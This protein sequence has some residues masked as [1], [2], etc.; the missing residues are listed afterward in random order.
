MAMSALYARDN[1]S[2]T[3][4]GRWRPWKV[5]YGDDY[6]LIVEDSSSEVPG[7]HAEMHG[8]PQKWAAASYTFGQ[9]NRR[10]WHG[11][12]R[13][14]KINIEEFIQFF[15]KRGLLERLGAPTWEGRGWWRFPLQGYP[16]GVQASERELRDPQWVQAWHGTTIY[17]AP[18]IIRYG[19]GPS[20]K[21]NHRFFDERPGVYT[22]TN[23][24]DTAHK[25]EGYVYYSVLMPGSG[26]LW[27]T[28]FELLGDF[29][30]KFPWN[31]KKK[32]TGEIKKTDQSIFRYPHTRMVAMWAKGMTLDLADPSEW[33]FKSWE[34]T[35]EFPDQMYP[36]PEAD[37]N[38]YV[39]RGDPDSAVVDQLSGRGPVVQRP[40]GIPP[41]PNQGRGD[42]I[43]RLLSPSAHSAASSSGYFVPRTDVWECEAAQG[44][45]EYSTEVCDGINNAFQSGS[46][47]VWEYRSSNKK[48]NADYQID[49]IAGT[50]LNPNTG[51]VRKIRRKHPPIN[52]C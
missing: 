19:V 39:D 36:V 32:S 50:Q 4:A 42:T 20:F 12:P 27:G 28:K 30:E 6:E 23:I 1:P 10:V 14:S 24:N 41:D 15:T 37:L 44:W 5:A 29:R 47:F 22:H 40:G 45:T 43:A 52:S 48:H 17:A 25:C 16:P 18:N 33:G 38:Q 26:V 51:M 9:K 49:P 34:P 31:Y 13:D 35:W 11:L 46:C 3:N 21:E 8:T 2:G 7:P